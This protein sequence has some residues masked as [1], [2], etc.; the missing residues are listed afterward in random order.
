MK[1]LARRDGFRVLAGETLG[2]HDRP[3]ARVEADG[4]ARAPMGPVAHDFSETSQERFHL[5]FDEAI[6]FPLEPLTEMV[7][8]RD[9]EQHAAHTQVHRSRLMP[10]HGADSSNPD[11]PRDRIPLRAMT[12]RS[13]SHADRAAKAGRGIWSS[14]HS[15]N[16]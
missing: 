4:G 3:P 13:M 9:L 14:G 11:T 5:S 7:V 12:E 8:L 6:D 2:V 10:F 15:A 16:S 1:F